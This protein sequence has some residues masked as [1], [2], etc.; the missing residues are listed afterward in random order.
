MSEPDACEDPRE[1]LSEDVETEFVDSV[2]EL[3]QRI[4]A[5]LRSGREQATTGDDDAATDGGRDE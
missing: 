2:G 4:A 5:D 3:E 1:M